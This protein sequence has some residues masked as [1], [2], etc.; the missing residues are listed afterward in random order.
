MTWFAAVSGSPQAFI[1]RLTRAQQAYRTVTGLPENRGVDPSL[2][3]IAQDVVGAYFAQ[4]KSLLDDRRSF[5]PALASQIVP[6]IKQ[7]GRNVEILPCIPGAVER[8]ARMLLAEPVAPDSAMFELVMASNYATYGFD[9]AFIEE[10]PG[11]NRTPDLRLSAAGV[12][13]QP[14]RFDKRTGRQ[15][16]RARRAAPGEFSGM[17]SA[18]AGV[19]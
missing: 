10:A 3:M 17:A 13:A 18:D 15:A 9:V 4:A 11:Q 12:I 7:I 1:E 16:K 5:D 2:D 6:W 14:L 8:A 19:L